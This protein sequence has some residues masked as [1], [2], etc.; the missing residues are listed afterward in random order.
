M[1]RNVLAAIRDW[2]T[3]VVPADFVDCDAVRKAGVATEPAGLAAVF[4][5]AEAAA[6]LT[7]LNK[8]DDSMWGSPCS[9][10]HNL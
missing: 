10:N 5:T 9:S 2:A 6:V 1:L 3:C 7:G 8:P 4:T